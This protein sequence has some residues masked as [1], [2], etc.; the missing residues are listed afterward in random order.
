M[1]HHPYW[2]A[3]VIGFGDA[4]SKKVDVRFFGDHEMWNTTASDCLLY[5]KTNPNKRLN[6]DLI[7]RFEAAVKVEKNMKTDMALKKSSQK[8]TLLSIFRRLTS[9]C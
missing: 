7:D 5:T 2:P 8:V 9:T 3:K 6:V 4:G 1:T